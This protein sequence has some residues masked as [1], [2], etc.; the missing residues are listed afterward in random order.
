MLRQNGAPANRIAAIED[1]IV[2]V[3]FRPLE[4]AGSAAAT[5]HNVP[6]CKS[7]VLAELLRNELTK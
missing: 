2:A 3:R 7:M 6:F 4:V 1:N 5:E